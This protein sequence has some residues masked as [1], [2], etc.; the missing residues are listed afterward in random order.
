MATVQR[1]EELQVWQKARVL[2]K[3]IWHLTLAGPLSRD[4]ELKNQINGASGSVMDNIAEGFGRGGRGE[5]VHMLTVS[6]GS[7][8]EVKS[9]LYRALDREHI[10]ETQ[11]QDLYNQA[12]QLTKMLVAFVN[13]L[14]RTSYKGIKAKKPYQVTE[15]T[16]N[17]KPQTTNR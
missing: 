15:P 14:N 13:Y 10:T 1:F 3:A 5:F 8:D 7:C 4:F 9:Q 12:D 2:S 6:C 11:F 16:T 17:Y